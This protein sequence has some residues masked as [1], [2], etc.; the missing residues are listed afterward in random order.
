MIRSKISYD[1]KYIAQQIDN[2]LCIYEVKKGVIVYNIIPDSAIIDFDFSL[3]DS[4]IFAMGA[5]RENNNNKQE[6]ISIYHIPDGEILVEKELCKDAIIQHLWSLSFVNNKKLLIG[7]RPINI[8]SNEYSLK[9]LDE[10]L[11]DTK[12]GYKFPN[13]GNLPHRDFAR[14]INYNKAQRYFA[15]QGFFGSIIID[16][17]GKQ[18]WDEFQQ[19]NHNNIEID[20]FSTYDSIDVQISGNGLYLAVLF[21]GNDNSVSPKVFMFDLREKKKLGWFFE[22]IPIAIKQI[23]LSL[24]GNYLIGIPKEKGNVICYDF[25]QKKFINLVDVYDANFSPK[26]D[27]KIF[28]I[29]PNRIIPLL[30]KEEGVPPQE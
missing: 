15:I 16:A 22:N 9:I 24:N 1:E 8:R 6:Y 18:I 26:I 25:I 2:N 12:L 27:D 28:Q 7:V 14:K 21:E 11:N 10:F 5:V 29:T 3:E 17:N 23:K 19:F 13:V 20:E 30:L 4:S